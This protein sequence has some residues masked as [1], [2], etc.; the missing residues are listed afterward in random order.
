MKEYIYNIP[1]KEKEDNIK[2]EEKKE[3]YEEN[4]NRITYTLIKDGKP[5]LEMYKYEFTKQ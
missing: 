1:V 2:V 4:V 5:I 3:L